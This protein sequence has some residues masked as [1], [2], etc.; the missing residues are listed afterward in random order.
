MERQIMRMVSLI[1]V[2]LVALLSVA[3]APPEPPQNWAERMFGTRA[4]RANDFGI[5]PRGGILSHD[6][7]VTNVH[8]FPIE[9][10]SVRRY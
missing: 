5:V 1:A 6:F 4:D 10:I 3:A 9:V 8:P 2:G 7:V